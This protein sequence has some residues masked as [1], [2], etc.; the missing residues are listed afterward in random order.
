MFYRIFTNILKNILDIHIFLM[1]KVRRQCT[2]YLYF[3]IKS[4]LKIF[5][6]LYIVISILNSNSTFFYYTLKRV[7][8][9]K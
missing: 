7:L 4:T 5:M 6:I 3:C 8:L 2:Q 9:K 1:Y